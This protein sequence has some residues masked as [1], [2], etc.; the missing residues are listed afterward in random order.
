MNCCWFLSPLSIIS[1]SLVEFFIC[2]LPISYQLI[3]LDRSLPICSLYCYLIVVYLP[4]V[5]GAKR[6]RKVLQDNV[7]GQQLRFGVRISDILGNQWRCRGG[8]QPGEPARPRWRS[9]GTVQS[10]GS[11]ITNSNLIEYSNYFIFYF[12]WVKLW[13]RDIVW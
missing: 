6:H 7:R 13:L 12:F 11:L 9:L 5:F 8:G 3:W 10:W 4:W 2:V 1:N